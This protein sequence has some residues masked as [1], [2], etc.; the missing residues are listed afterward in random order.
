MT[1]S[2]P[3]YLQF[4]ILKLKSLIKTTEDWL[5]VV[6]NV[7]NQIDS[8]ISFPA[9]NPIR[10]TSQ[11][12]VNPTTRPSQI[13]CPQLTSRAMQRPSRTPQRPPTNVPRSQCWYCASN[14]KPSQFHWHKE[15]LL[16]QSNSTAYFGNE[17]SSQNEV[18]TT[19]RPYCH[20]Y[21]LTKRPQHEYDRLQEEVDDLIK[22]KLVRPST[23]P[24]AF[25]VMGI[26]KKDGTLRLV[27]DYR[28]LNADTIPDA[29]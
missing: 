5:D 9:T 29:D 8:N 2:L 19:P 23:S 7:K 4:E 16:K 25:P 26:P 6:T 3:S 17:E 10:T 11:R 21:E 18:A 22:K 12:I 20:E 28:R 27:V 24:Y 1:D 14:G 15:F 13:F